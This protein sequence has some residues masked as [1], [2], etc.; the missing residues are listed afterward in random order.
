MKASACLTRDIIKHPIILAMLLMVS[1]ARSELPGLRPYGGFDYLNM[2]IMRSQ[3][4]A[5]IDTGR[6]KLGAE[7][8]PYFALEV[9]AGTGFTSD[10]E[11]D[12]SGD[13]VEWELDKIWGLYARGILPLH[14]RIKIYALAGITRTDFKIDISTEPGSGH[15]SYSGYSYGMGVEVLPIDNV[16]L[17]AEF[18]SLIDELELTGSRDEIEPEI[19]GI[20]LGIKYYF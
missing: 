16:S 4:K 19:S 6:F 15:I 5:S 10:R 13:Y 2:D 9:Q 20:S 12:N 7:L 11:E 18:V 14:N 1:Y 8:N 17:V 3:R